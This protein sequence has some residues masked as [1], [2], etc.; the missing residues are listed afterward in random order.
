VRHV[1]AAIFAVK[2]VDRDQSLLS[3]TGK[4]HVGANH[5]PK[6]VLAEERDLYKYPDNRKP[7]EHERNH[8]N[9]IQ[10]RSPILLPKNQV[11]STDIS[12]LLRWTTRATNLA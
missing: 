3:G 1:S 2:F 10:R 6:C 11:N 9:E 5:D 7:D 8:K 12:A 4:H